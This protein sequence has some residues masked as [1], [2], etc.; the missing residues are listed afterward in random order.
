MHL[1]ALVLLALLATHLGAAPSAPSST[2]TAPPGTASTVGRAD[3]VPRAPR[4]PLVAVLPLAAHKVDS[5][6]AL[7]LTDALGVR[8]QATGQYRLMERAQIDRVLSEQG[9]QQSGACSASDCAIE[10]GRL[11]GIDQMVVGTVGLLGQTYTMSARRVSVESGEI[12][13]SAS[14]NYSGRIDGLLVESI[15][16]LV[17]ELGRNAPTPATSMTQSDAVANLKAHNEIDFLLEEKRILTPKELDRIQQASARL[18]TTE[19]QLLWVR[20]KPASWTGWLNVYP[21]FGVGSAVQRDWVGFGVAGGMMLV[22]AASANSSFGALLM[23]GGFGFGV[24]RGFD[25]P[26]RRTRDLRKALR[27]DESTAY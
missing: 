18:G 25:I 13:A 26:K 22:G 8:L 23:I 16:A 6:E 27:L 4:I 24:Y 21:S 5:E 20:H 14:S 9:F 12:L 11:L 10:M 7:V 1:P 19:R 17:Q 3:S 15:P 2:P